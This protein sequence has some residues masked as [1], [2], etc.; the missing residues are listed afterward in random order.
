M[1]FTTKILIVVI[2]LLVAFVIFGY[3]NDRTWLNKYKGIVKDKAD[4]EVE[5][6]DEIQKILAEK[7]QLKKELDA[8]KASRKVLVNED[9]KYKEQLSQIYVPANPN[10]LVVAYRKRGF[11]TARILSRVK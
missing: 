6:T 3:I 2:S 9:E 8:L 5:V 10:E 7:A 1:T 11:S 4:L